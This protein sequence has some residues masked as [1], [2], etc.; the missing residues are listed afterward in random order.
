MRVALVLFLLAMRASA[1]CHPRRM[2]RLPQAG[3]FR[4]AALRPSLPRAWSGTRRPAAPLDDSGALG[5]K[6]VLESPDLPRALRL[7][8]TSSEADLDDAQR[9]AMDIAEGL[10]TCAPYI[11][12]HRGQRIVVHIP[13][14]V[15]AD[16][17][18]FHTIMDDIALVKLLGMKIVVVLGARHLIDTAL[19]L[20][21]IEPKFAA[22]MRVTDEATMQV[23][24][25]TAGASRF[26]VES[27]LS[28]GFQAMPGGS[29]CQVVGGSGFFSAQPIGV[30]GGVDFGYT[31]AIRR[32]D[33]D[34]VN[35][36]LDDGDLVVLTGVGHSSSGAIFNCR[37]PEVASVVARSI[38]AAKLV[39]V[40]ASGEKL[41][42]KDS[43]KQITNLRLRDAKELFGSDE[44]FGEAKDHDDPLERQLR[45][46]TACRCS[47]AAVSGGVRRAHLVPP[48]R[49]ALLQ[50]LY[51]RDGYG[52]MISGDV[53]D[54]LRRALP[55]DTE[56]IYRLI[57]PLAESGVMRERTRDCVEDEISTYHVCFRDDAVLACGQLKVFGDVGEIGAMAVDPKYRG[58]G[59]GEAMLNYLER[60]ACATDL[61]RLMVLSTNT[62]EWFLERGFV[63]VGVDALPQEK[64][65]VYDHQ[66]KSKIYMKEISQRDVDA[67]ELFWDIGMV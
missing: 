63:E 59:R 47:V 41:I 50:E 7:T 33:A 12:R 65:D 27:M 61:D 18:H 3:F 2:G 37:T 11:H 60:V 43:G 25:E 38:K 1:L 56:A 22:G 46:R 58:A 49:G 9:G 8:L 14:H 52:T 19:R 26:E 15:I 30:R 32:V 45:W 57:R 23:V 4:R 17:A 36:R 34:R 28:K 35:A 44:E 10:R 51:T 54:G 24:K 39:F 31:G 53:Y 13:G 67:E 64:K 66:R 21:G 55:K 40:T 20:R 5:D 6:E 62:M 16:P 42:D 29:G 48:G